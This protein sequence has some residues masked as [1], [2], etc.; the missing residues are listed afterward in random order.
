MTKLKDERWTDK[1]RAEKLA[2]AMYPYLAPASVQRE[3]IAGNQ[4]QR[5]GFERR[6]AEGN[7]QYGKAPASVEPSSYD[8][9]PGL[10]RVAPNATGPKSWWEK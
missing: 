4:E 9:V 8:R 10:K 2:T 1:S 6:I 5:S 7:R 3:M